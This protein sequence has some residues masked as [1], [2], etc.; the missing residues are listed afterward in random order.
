MVNDPYLVLGVSRNAT[1]EEIKK[2]YR[3]KAKEYHPDLHPNDPEAAQRMNEINEAYD[4]LQHPEKYEARRKQQEQRQSQN[5]AYRGTYQQNTGYG[6]GSRN[7]GQ[8]YGGYR[9]PG[10]WSSDFGGFSFEDLFGFGFGKSAFDVTP[11]AQS[12]DSPEMVGAINAV[13]SRRYQEA[14][15]ILSGI[16]SVYRNDRWY[17]VSA[18]AHYGNGDGVRAQELLQRAIQMA[19]ENRMYQQLYLQY[20]NEEQTRSGTYTT[21]MHQTPMAFMGK[22][23]MGLIL[24]QGILFFFRLFFF[25]L[26]FGY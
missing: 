15:R 14:I 2:A 18:V 17:Y 10:G 13:N 23:M 21:E 9:G 11:H 4:M 1:Q 16:I 12:G 25:G 22:L 8:D 3:R 20:R 7:A 24:L 19:P 26:Q 5:T 6:S